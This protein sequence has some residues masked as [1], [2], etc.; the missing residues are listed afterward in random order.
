M[1]PYDKYPKMKPA[2]MAPYNKYPKMKPT[3]PSYYPKSMMPVQTAKKPMPTNMMK[4]PIAAEET[5]PGLH[6]PPRQAPAMY[7]PERV[8]VEHVYKP[9]IVPHIHPL[10]TLIQTH[11]IYEHRHYYPHK[12]TK[13]CDERHYDVQAERP[14]FAKPHC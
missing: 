7:D 9:V 10:R 13:R 8:R 12:V 1:A 4:K 6:C 3:M 11:Y 2:E 5:G 14:C